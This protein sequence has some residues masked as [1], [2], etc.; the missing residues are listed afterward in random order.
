MNKE[1]TLFDLMTS[2]QKSVIYNKARLKN[3]TAGET[4]FNRGDFAEHFYLVNKGQIKIL[5][6]MST[7]DEKVFKVFTHGGTIAEVAMFVPSQQYPMTA[8]AEIDTQVSVFHKK[9]LFELIETSPQLALAI[10]RFMSQRIASLMD[11]IDTLTQVNADQRL[12][13]FFAQQYAK[14]SSEKPSITLPYAKKVL[15]GQLSIKP[16][17]LSRI[18]KKFKQNELIIEQGSQVSFPD[19]NKLCEFVQVTPDLF[20]TKKNQS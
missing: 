20:K 16:E 12:V 8:I 2:E 3:L 18:L 10:M 6:L 17:T 5:R 9:H 19:I 11:T 13:M 15:A 1:F 4:L 14:Q 7:G